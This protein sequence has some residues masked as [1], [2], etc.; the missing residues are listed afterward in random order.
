METLLVLFAL[1]VL[2]P[3]LD[4]FGIVVPEKAAHDDVEQPCDNN[5]APIMVASAHVQRRDPDQPVRSRREVIPHVD[6]NQNGTAK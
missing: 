4:N 3:Q 2:P 1:K 6:G 5:D